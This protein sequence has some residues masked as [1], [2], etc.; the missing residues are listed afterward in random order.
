MKNLFK[1]IVSTTMSL[2]EKFENYTLLVDKVWFLI[3]S[4]H[5]ESKTTYIFRS[6]NEEL[7][8]SNNGNIK[9]GKWE[10]I[11]TSNCLLL[12]IDGVSK[13][14][15]VLYIRE[16]YLVFQNDYNPALFV[17]VNESY[18]RNKYAKL[19]GKILDYVLRDIG[20]RQFFVSEPPKTVATLVQ[21]NKI[22]NATNKPVPV[23][24]A[25]P[26]AKEKVKE[27]PK[28]EIKID[29]KNDMPSNSMDESM[30]RLDDI[31]KDL[32][33]HTKK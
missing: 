29:L 30:K 19:S 5:N 13:L 2:G 26:I 18:Y 17:F 7:L 21:P 28:E 24:P 23:E 15:Q 8:I 12:D 20:E 3:N 27:Q 6:K 16:H 25:N 31:I 33:K 14:F 9:K 1:G 10:Y 32:E 4:D 11:K 22:T